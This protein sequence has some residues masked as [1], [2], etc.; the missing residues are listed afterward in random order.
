ML[1]RLDPT[2]H[3]LLA[4]MV[5]YEPSQRVSAR[6][7]LDDA[8]FALAPTPSELRAAAAAAAGSAAA[9]AASGGGRG[10]AGTLGMEDMDTSVDEGASL[11]SSAAAAVARKKCFWGERSCIGRARVRALL[12]R[13]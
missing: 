5:V 3:L 4:K 7:A 2:A 9:G 8:L 11:A 12:H 1:P 10:R 6:A 13:R